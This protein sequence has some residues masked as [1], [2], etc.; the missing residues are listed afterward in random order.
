MLFALQL[1]MQVIG[2]F[3]VAVYAGL[4]IDTYFN[5]KPIAILILLFLA[6][7]YIIKLLLGVGKDD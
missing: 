7:G 3:L 2:A 1:G 6:F 4:K 5:S